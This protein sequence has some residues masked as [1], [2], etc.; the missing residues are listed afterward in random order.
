MMGEHKLQ[1]KLIVVGLIALIIGGVLYPGDVLA[2]GMESLFYQANGYYEEGDYLKAAETYEKILNMGYAS[3]NV[4]YNL[5]N[6]YYRSGQKGLA[7]ANYLR[8]KSLI[9][10]DPDLQANLAHLRSEL[11]LTEEGVSLGKWLTAKVG[12]ML[13]VRESATIA[14]VFF[15]LLTLLIILTVIFPDWKQYVKIP[16][17]VLMV[18]LVL[19]G[20]GTVLSASYH[21]HGDLAVVVVNETTARFEPSASGGAH[22]T[23]SEGM[24]ATID[25]E[26]E[27]WVQIRRPDGKKGWVKADEVEPLA[28]KQTR[29]SEK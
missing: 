19:A 9:P 5:A 17:I 12:D 26:R 14:T 23:I 4:Y 27:G 24:F 15:T 20:I 10:R 25:G 29:R 18:C 1:L 21:N 16:Q 6:A 13:T 7:M 22:Y 11:K 8:A 2:S 28:V 3:G